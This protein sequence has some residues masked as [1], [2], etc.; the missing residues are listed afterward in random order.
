MVRKSASRPGDA[1][2]DAL[3]ERQPVDALLVGVRVPEME[4]GQVG[5]AQL[6]HERHRGAGIEGDQEDVRVRALVALGPDALA[7]G[8]GGDAGRAEIGPDHARG[9]EPEMRRDQQTVDLLVGV[10]GEREDDPVGPGAGFARLHGD[11]AHDAVAARVRSRCGS[12]RRPSG[13]ARS[14]GA[15]SMAFGRADPPARPR[16]PVRTPARRGTTKAAK[17]RVMAKETIRNASVFRP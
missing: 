6:G 10:V 2:D 3:V 7:R 1:D 17:R 4:L 8:D 15:R 16:R 14:S 12:R 13:S 5:R 11:A 9:G